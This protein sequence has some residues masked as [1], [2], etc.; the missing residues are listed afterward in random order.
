MVIISKKE[1]EHME[2]LYILVD[3]LC[4][5]YIIDTGEMITPLEMVEVI[6]I[7]AFQDVF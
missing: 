5:Q 7:N 1:Y 6:I 4:I 3:S 2:G